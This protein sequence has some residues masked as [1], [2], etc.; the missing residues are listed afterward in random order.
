MEWIKLM[1]CDKLLSLIDL[2][3]IDL[4]Y[5]VEIMCWIQGQFVDLYHFFEIG[6][7][8]GTTTCVT[9]PKRMGANRTNG[10]I[11]WSA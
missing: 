4:L 8:N 11:M 7:G 10:L 9:A 2:E 3:N 6:L 5:Y 1:F